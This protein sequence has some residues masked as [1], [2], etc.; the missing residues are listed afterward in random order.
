MPSQ[1]F[2]KRATLVPCVLLATLGALAFS[3]A[4][5]GG[6]VWDD[7][8]LISNNAAWRSAS[9]LWRA[10]GSSF[11]ET[12]VESG[13]QARYYRPLISL[14]YYA[15][16]RLFGLEPRGY[17]VVNLVLHVGCVL[18]AFA[19]L[20]DRLARAYG[21][22]ATSGHAIQLGAAIGAG[23]F[24]LH[25]SR[26]EAVSWISGC[27]DL[28]MAIFALGAALCVRSE[29]AASRWL[30]APL[31]AAAALLCKEAAVMLPPLLVLDAL[32]L[33]P[34]EA[35]RAELRAAAGIGAA[36]LAVLVV[37]SL[38][39]PL[40]IASLAA[41]L[42]GD[43]VARV[44]SSFGHYLE[45]TFSPWAPTVLRGEVT[46]GVAGPQYEP[47]SVMLGALGFA[48]SA[49]LC[50][51]ALRRPALRP[52]LADGAWFVLALLPVLNLLPL[53]LKALVADRYLYLPMLGISALLARAVAEL[54]PRARTA[55]R[56]A[57]GAVALG[58][59]LAFM[60]VTWS[61]SRA[62]ASD[63]A[64]WQRELALDPA[65]RYVLE[66]NTNMRLNA[67][68]HAGAQALARAGLALAHDH[69]VDLS[70]GFKLLA[71]RAAVLA[72][73]DSDRVR[74]LE[75]RTFYD[76]LAGGREAMIEL[77]DPGARA[78]W[79]LTF[80]DFASPAKAKLSA[81]ELIDFHHTRAELHARTGDLPGART[82]LADAL[83]AFPRAAALL[84]RLAV[85]HAL[86]HRFA[87][88]NAA[89]AEAV[90]LAPA[91][92][93][94]LAAR[95]A[96]VMA[97]R[98]GASEPTDAR[99]SVLRDAQIE[100]LLGAFGL[101]RARLAAALAANP[102]DVGLIALAVRTD[103]LDRRPDLARARLEQAQRAH[104]ESAAHWQ[105]LLAELR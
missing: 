14:A 1:L 64:L 81:S 36:L 52:W 17:H 47:P 100:L 69:G 70:T 73:R 93:Y 11:W 97:S 71:A 67:G 51:L 31:L 78:P 38:L 44:V 105:S 87:A 42:Q 89:A 103:A 102:T 18:L 98:I 4:L 8:L 62:F 65:R 68:D 20:R 9:G 82:V 66:A 63:D 40:P 95:R 43:T 99:T 25:P 75:L 19:W 84:A 23:W 48:L 104:P 27:T 90:R 41:G 56:V 92:R 37:R 54:W 29:R 80:D 46:I 35:R 60:T 3:P 12:S 53:G 32:C 86:E 34:P 58:A 57:C 91:A 94:A 2:P 85:I 5:A 26:T 79:V 77:D 88:A 22:L 21:S 16:F 13:A 61:H 96:V 76:R 59:A 10:L 49:L 30:L 45:A 15:Q 33:S 50:V 101:A 28:W 7:H 55:A 39:V 83:R 6:F 74:L 24:A 72:T